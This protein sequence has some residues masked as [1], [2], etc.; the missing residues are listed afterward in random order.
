VPGTWYKQLSDLYPA[1]HRL[2]ASLA[3]LLHLS[4]YWKQLFSLVEVLQVKEILRAKLNHGGCGE[5]GAQKKEVRNLI[6]EVMA[7]CS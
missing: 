5:K 7:M 1:V 3:L 6:G 4:P 2:T